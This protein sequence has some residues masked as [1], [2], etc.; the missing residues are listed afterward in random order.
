MNV[1]VKVWS[2]E[3]CKSSHYRT[4]TDDMLCAGGSDKDSCYVS[5]R[6]FSSDRSSRNAYFCRS[7]CLSVCPSVCLSVSLSVWFKVL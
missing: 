4:I 1:D 6:I 7:V 3:D 5:F 2:N